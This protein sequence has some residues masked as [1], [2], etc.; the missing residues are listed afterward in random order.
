MSG[1]INVD[2]TEDVRSEVDQAIFQKEIGRCGIGA[3]PEL[4]RK[5]AR[6][7]LA[8]EE[9]SAN[10]EVQ[11]EPKPMDDDADCP[12]KNLQPDADAA[13]L[14]HPSGTQNSAEDCTQ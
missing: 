13:Q 14:N 1:L 3:A 5:E 8:N 12:G 7:Y 4:A 11:V 10:Q 6:G 2:L 9:V